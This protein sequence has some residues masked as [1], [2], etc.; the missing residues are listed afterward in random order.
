MDGA[1]NGFEGVQLPGVYVIL[2]VFF[3]FLPA[4]PA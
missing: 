1:T 2:G 3:Y 4:S